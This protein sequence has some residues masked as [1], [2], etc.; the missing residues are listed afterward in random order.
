MMIVAKYL[1]ISFGSDTIWAKPLNFL[2]F[3]FLI[4]SKAIPIIA[5]ICVIIKYKEHMELPLVVNYDLKGTI[6]KTRYEIHKGLLYISFTDNSEIVFTNANN[7]DAG[8]N[9]IVSINYSR[10]PDT[11]LILESLRVLEKSTDS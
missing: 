3:M 10:I 1:N 4:A 8:V 5:I 9:D 11:S 2:E 7:I 6:S